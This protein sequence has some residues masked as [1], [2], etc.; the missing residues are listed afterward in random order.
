MFVGHFHGAAKVA[1]G[2]AFDQSDEEGFFAQVGPLKG[3]TGQTCLFK[4]DGRIA[5]IAIFTAGDFGK[6]APRFIIPDGVNV[7]TN[8]IGNIPGS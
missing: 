5:T 8:V 3:Q 4:M 2:R 1:S 6:V 7:D